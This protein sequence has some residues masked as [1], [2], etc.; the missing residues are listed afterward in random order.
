MAG[1]VIRPF[2]VYPKIVLVFLMVAMPLY[3]LGF[4]MNQS[5]SNKVKAEIQ[6]SLESR[7]HFYL[8][9]FE[10]EFQRIVKLRNEYVYDGD[11]Q[12]ISVIAPVMTDYQLAEAVMRIVEKL[13]LLKSSSLYV[14]NIRVHIPLIEKTISTTGFTDPMSEEDLHVLRNM[15]NTP[16]TSIVSS[17][18]RLIIGGVYPE[19]FD[20]G[21]EPLYA[22]EVELSKDK[23]RQSLMDV[24]KNRVGEAVLI[25]GDN[26]WALSSSPDEAALAHLQD[27]LAAEQ[28]RDTASGSRSWDIEGTTYSVIYNRSSLLD[29]M[30]VF[31]MPE[32]E[33]LGSLEESRNWLWWLSITS[34]LIVAIFSLWIYKLIHRPVRKLVNA[35]RRVE[36]GEL[37]VAVYHKPADE[38][39]YLYKQ[40]NAMVRRLQVLIH[41]VYEQKLRSQRSE[42]KQLQSQ[43]NPHFLYNSYFVLHRTM[44]LGEADKALRLSKHLG[45]YFR[46]ITRSGSDE[47]LLSAEWK[48]TLAFVE[49]Q[50][51]RFSRRM[52]TRCGELADS[53]G[54]IRVPKLILQPIIENAYEHG[55]T[56]KMAGGLV[57]LTLEQRT[58]QTEEVL[59]IIVEDNG[60]GLTD[61]RV[62]EMNGQ[63]AMGEEVAETTGMMNVHRRLQ[64][65]FGDAYG[66]FLS[67]GTLGGLR[68]EMKIPMKA[69]DRDETTADRR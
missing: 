18:N 27:F 57:E 39:G 63:L 8:S 59:L 23:I 33:L 42:L 10:A 47:V 52:E 64:L 35:L 69:G 58:E 19:S 12:E 46:Y 55:L 21:Q 44:Q 3:I 66:L 45:E 49:I 32:R 30:L 2:S 20:A 11:L 48:H 6:Q 34:V 54:G 16:D 60:E 26:A 14:S 38:F 7:V 24:D 22:I 67:R 13:K 53:W 17:N 28:D 1:T 36:K 62:D 15:K 56:D 29:T 31:S 51:L 43:I 4:A 50:M 37:G 40:F 25:G 65:K 9:A 68:V 41:E 61:E 5:G